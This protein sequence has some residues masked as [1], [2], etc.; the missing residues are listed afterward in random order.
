MI[1]FRSAS[2]SRIQSAISAIVL[3][4]PSQSPDCGSIVQMRMQGE[5][6]VGP[7]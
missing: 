6:I 3:P 2:S 1:A 4:Q 7:R 5:I